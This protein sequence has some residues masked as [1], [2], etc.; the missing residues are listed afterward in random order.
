MVDGG[1]TASLSERSSRW[2]PQICGDLLEKKERLSFPSGTELVR[3]G[4]L[5]SFRHPS[6]P[7]IS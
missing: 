5:F 3:I 4:L 6:D 1:N 7:P 2:N